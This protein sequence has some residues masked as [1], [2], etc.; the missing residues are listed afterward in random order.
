MD[1][2]AFKQR[3]QNLKSYR[4]NNPGKGYWDWK[5]EAFAEGGKINDKYQM[6]GYYSNHSG[7]PTMYVPITKQSEEINV[8]TP[9]IT[10]TPK[11]NI[12]IEAAIDK[13][14]KTAFENIKEVAS[15]TPVVGDA[16]DVSDAVYQAT[17]GNY[18]KAAILGGL[19]LLPNII[20]KPI[21]KFA[22]LFKSN[23]K[24][25]DLNIV[26][27]RDYTSSKPN[28]INSN[29]SVIKYKRKPIIQQQKQNNMLDATEQNR[30]TIKPVGEFV[31]T[32]TISDNID[33][34]I[35]RDY[36]FNPDYGDRLNELRQANERI[37]E[38]QQQYQRM[39]TDPNFV[40]TSSID[41]LVRERNN[42]FDIGYDDIQYQ[43][44]MP[45]LNQLSQPLRDLPFINR[46]ELRNIALANN[47]RIHADDILNEYADILASTDISQLQH[48]RDRLFDLNLDIDS[49]LERRTTELYDQIEDRI[50]AL[51]G[52][53]DSGDNVAS[54]YNIS[55]QPYNRDNLPEFFYRD[56]ALLG[57]RKNASYFNMSPRQA[58]KK[59]TKDFNNLQHGQAW[60]LTDDYSVSTDSYPLQ[61]NL[62]SKY[63]DSGKISAVHDSDGSVRTMYLNSFGN[64]KGDA[65]IKR[66]NKKIQNISEIIGEDLPKAVQN[67]H[68]IKVPQIYYRK[69]S[70]GGQTGDPEKERFYQAT[71]R[72]SS[73]RPLEEGLKPVFSLEDAANMTPIGDAISARD[74]YNAVKNR[75]WLGA[76]LAAVTMIPFVPTTVRN[77]RKKYK[78]ITPKREIPTVNKKAIDNAIDE[79]KNYRDSRIKLYQQAI[80]DRNASYERLIENEDAL[81][82][83]VNFDKKYGTNY[84]KTYTKQ[85][86]NYAKSKNSPDLMQIGIKP[87]GANGSFDPNI[88]D[89]V[90]I[91]SDYVKNG[92]LQ[93][94]LISHEKS[95][96]DNQKAGALNLPIFDNRFI[97]TK[98][99][100]TMYPK[101]YDWIQRYLHNFEETKSHMNEFRTNMINKNLLKPDSR[102]G[103]KQ[104]KDL[105]F[106][107]D[108]DNMKKLFNTYKSKR[109]FVKDFNSVPITSIGDNKTLV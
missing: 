66:I 81:R 97:D 45:E 42:L 57:D 64:L 49:E 25:H 87:M 58:V 39:L 51:Q 54:I 17:Q 98:K 16:M 37:P 84:V 67:G 91:N 96:Y 101:T 43:F 69:Y 30:N 47:D 89:Y 95:H 72:S 31:H 85:L 6:K 60:H 46:Y 20:Q 41:E 9:E 24:P 106:N 62:M 79:A 29:K 103:L 38:L 8:Y 21:Q 65:S 7:N 52:T 33:E 104:I 82:R 1:R 59:A 40:D 78:G 93:P 80:E 88:P 32:Q 99:T 10:V 90:F 34:G 26:D 3:M 28:V 44:G 15:Y 63:K 70:D 22:K 12:S 74:T 109:Q 35:Y 2:Q 48:A 75:D 73:G 108:N 94:G 23:K 5:V 18:S 50:A 19:A 71:G 105:I 92:K 61:L 107:S 77:F 53:L 55:T 83:A 102:V 86:Q 100:K 4:E 68:S 36:L 76:G 27:A 56:E 13:G 11:D 14:R